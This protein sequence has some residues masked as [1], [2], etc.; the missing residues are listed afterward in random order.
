[1]LYTT[2]PNIWE[3]VLQVIDL[4]L[5]EQ[6]G[7]NLLASDV[8]VDVDYVIPRRVRC[9]QRLLIA[10]H[11]S[12]AKRHN[13]LLFSLNQRSQAPSNLCHSFIHTSLLSIHLFRL[14]CSYR[15]ISLH[16]KP[17]TFTRGLQYTQNNEGILN[18]RV[19]ACSF[20]NCHCHPRLPCLRTLSLRQ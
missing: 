13:F 2:W 20:G 4:I 14:N 17:T 11:F 7:E 12:L 5:I 9:K 15:T 3:K 10:L 8:L 1:M 18:P 19:A 16:F 6:L